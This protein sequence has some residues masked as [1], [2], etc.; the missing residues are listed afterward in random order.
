[1]IY[2]YDVIHYAHTRRTSVPT[3]ARTHKEKKTHAEPHAHQWNSFIRSV[4]SH[5]GVSTHIHT[6]AGIHTHMDTRASA[7]AKGNK[8]ARARA[9][10]SQVF[11]S[12]HVPL[13]HRIHTQ[14]SIHA[15]VCACTYSEYLTNVFYRFVSFFLFTQ[16]FFITAR[17]GRK[18]N[19]DVAGQ[20][21]HRVITASCCSR[22]NVPSSSSF[23][24]RPSPD[25]LIT[26]PSLIHYFR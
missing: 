20:C 25:L 18:C 14:T 3:G 16:R 15:Y 5:A 9:H 26:S 21:H 22:E 2:L 11:P 17:I 13:R 1:M 6:C 8:L 19:R 7:Q 12:V 23:F 10:V 4:L 24:Q